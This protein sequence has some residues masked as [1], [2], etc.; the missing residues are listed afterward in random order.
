MPAALSEVPHSGSLRRS[1]LG[2]L[3]KGL[4]G[5]CNAPLGRAETRDIFGDFGPLPSRTAAGGFGAPPCG[6]GLGVGLGAVPRR[7]EPLRRAPGLD[8]VGA[9][10]GGLLPSSFPRLYQLRLQARDNSL[11]RANLA[12]LLH[13]GGPERQAA[14]VFSLEESLVG[15][16]GPGVGFL[17]LPNAK[18]FALCDDGL[19]LLPKSSRPLLQELGSEGVYLLKGS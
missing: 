6:F 7:R 10:P 13:Q 18:E 9:P 19:A 17:L 12:A 11:Q 15:R 3:W 4:G 1:T 2:G 16:Q 14:V 5:F 8:G